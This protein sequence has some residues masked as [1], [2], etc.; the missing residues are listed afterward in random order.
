M[1]GIYL[2]KRGKLR[3]ASTAF[4]RAVQG[5][6]ECYNLSRPKDVDLLC[7]AIKLAVDCSKFAITSY[8][9]LLP[10]M[11]VACS[12]KT[13]ESLVKLITCNDVPG[14]RVNVRRSGMFPEKL[15]VSECTTNHKMTME[16]LST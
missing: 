9:G 7:Q 15:Q 2:R 12:T 1:E 10:P 16:R 8:P 4:Q 5:Y 3:D 6:I 11:V 13:G 14:C